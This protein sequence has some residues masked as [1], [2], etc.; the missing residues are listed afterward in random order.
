VLLHNPVVLCTNSCLVFVVLD[1][2][3]SSEVLYVDLCIHTY[4][5]TY[6]HMYVYTY[7]HRYIHTYIHTIIVFTSKSTDILR[8]HGMC[9]NFIDKYK[10]FVNF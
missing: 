3:Y 10:F 6:V 1:D 8:V 9:D 2:F 5:H 4:I 7:I